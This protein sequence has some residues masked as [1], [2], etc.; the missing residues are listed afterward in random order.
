MMRSKEKHVALEI[1]LDGFRDSYNEL[2]SP[3][4]YMSRNDLLPFQ[5]IN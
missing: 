4:L 5:F 2:L 3:A 1:V